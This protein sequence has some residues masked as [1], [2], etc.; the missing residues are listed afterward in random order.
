MAEPWIRVHANIA[1]KRVILR[2]VAQLGLETNEA[3]GLLV[4]FWG[5]MS[6]LGNDGD[7]N[8]LADHEIESWAGWNK[9]GKRGQFAAFIRKSHTDEDG[10]VKEWDVY[11]GALEDRRAKDRDRQRRARERRRSSRERH[12]DGENDSHADGDV[13]RPRD[14]TQGSAPARANDTRRDETRRDETK[15]L[16]LSPADF[17]LACAVAAN[18]GLSEHPERPQLIAA[19]IGTNASTLEAAEEIIAAG[20]PLE[21][22]KAD[23]YGQAK[24]HKADK[25]SSLRYFVRGVIRAWERHGATETATSSSRPAAQ[26]A[27][28]AAWDD[29]AEKLKARRAANA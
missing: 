7:V 29:V 14:I 8:T 5:A 6:R 18:Q 26:S 24:S 10:R 15:E 20:V 19:I 25:V 13:T 11:A 4:R 17:G 27:D 12:A 28:D 23:I 16:L 21:F 1:D 9:R 2:A 3:I 22:A